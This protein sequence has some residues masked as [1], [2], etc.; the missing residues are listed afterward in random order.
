MGA[1]G[2]PLLNTVS[3]TRRYRS[4]R[5]HM[6]GRS[7]RSTGRRIVELLAGRGFEIAAR[8]TRKNTT[9]LTFARTL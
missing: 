5:I 2:A 9:D 6:N 8:H 4:C 1:C 3:S 7:G